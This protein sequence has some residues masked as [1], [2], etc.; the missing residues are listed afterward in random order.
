M[1]HRTALC[2]KFT[3]VRRCEGCGRVMSD[4]RID[5]QGRWRLDPHHAA[6]R[7]CNQKCAGKAR[8]AGGPAWLRK[9]HADYIVPGEE[10]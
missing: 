7:A 9:Y 8:E 10:S 3:P 2:P 5:R 1:T 4:V 6:R